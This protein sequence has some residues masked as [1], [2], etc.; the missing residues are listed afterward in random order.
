MKQNTIIA[1]T[2]MGLLTLGTSV[3]TLEAFPAEQ[4]KQRDISK[5]V[6]RIFEK[7][8]SDENGTISFDEFA[9]RKLEN[10]Q[11]TFTALDTDEDAMLTLEEIMAGR[12]ETGSEIDRDVLRQCVADALG[13]ELPVSMTAEERFNQADTNADGFIDWDEYVAAKTAK[14]QMKFDKIDTDINGEL[15]VDEVTAALTAHKAVRK[16]RKQCKEEQSEIDDLV[17]G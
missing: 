17:E 13:F 10:A 5:I 8:D 4:G 6:E 9:A 16:V 7:L 11:E 15:D 12:G 14:A 2:I 1:M 3:T